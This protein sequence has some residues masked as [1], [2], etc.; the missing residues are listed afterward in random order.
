VNLSSISG[1]ALLFVTAL[2]GGCLN[3]VAGGGTFL[4]FPALI[5]QGVPPVNANATSTVALWPGQ[6]ASIAAYRRELAKHDRALI[7]VLASASVAG[8]LTGSVLLLVTPQTTFV[9]IIPFLL[10]TATLLFAF[11][12]NI[13]IALSRRS[14]PPTPWQSRPRPVIWLAQFVMAVYGGYFG[15]GLGILM[16]AAFVVIGITD[17]QEANALKTLLAACIN[18]TAV[19]VFIVSGIVFW[20]QTLVMLVGAVIGGYT[21]ASIAR[22]INPEWIRGFVIFVGVAMTILFFVRS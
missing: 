13:V 5:F 21:A 16:L 6:W 22:H 7:A 3:A 20:P 10:L 1:W 2:I 17:I 8:G 14:G 11:G 19:L 9:R 15:G 18:G 4:T 12:R